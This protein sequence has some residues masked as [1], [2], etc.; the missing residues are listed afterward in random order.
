[1]KT[2][3]IV[4]LVW[5]SALAS[6]GQE[7]VDIKVASFNLRMDT[8]KDGV[9]AW[10]NRKE[11]VKALIQYHDFDIV[12]TQEGFEHQLNDLME[13][14]G[15]AYV[16]AGRDDGKSAGEHS[17]ILYKADLYEL[18]DSGNFWLSETPEKPGLGWDATCC[19]RI[20]SWALFRDKNSG[21]EF[22]V[23]NAHFDHQGVVARRESGKLM[24]KKIKEIAG[25]KAVICTGD[26]NS[27]PDTEQIVG[28]AAILDDAY[29]VSQMPPYGPVGTT[30]SFQFTAPMKK[31]IDYV[32]V[33][34]DFEVVKYAVLTDALDQRYPSDHLPVVASLRLMK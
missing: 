25:D 24:V 7:V 4:L 9:N 6:Y 20:A 33:S 10:P 23:F 18:L 12:G 30:N 27:T 22:Y 28:I 15:F 8:P 34:K 26:F 16:G 11:N 1:M 21:K 3:L 29:I 5:M 32:F 31:R 17:A 14:P 2:Y 13:M 19:K